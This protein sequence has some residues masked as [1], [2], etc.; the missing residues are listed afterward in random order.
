MLI[1]VSPAKSLD[2]D[3]RLATKKHSQP[4]LLDDAT[5][6]AEVMATKSPDD[7]RRLMTI[8]P[9]LA[10]LNFTRF[11]EWA[12]PFDRRNA[13]PAILTFNGDTYIGLDAPATFSERDYTHAQKVLR[14][15]SGLYGVLR[16]LDLIQPYRLEMGSRVETDRGRDLYGFWGD[17]ITRQ[18]GEDLD[19]SPGSRTLVNLASSE[20]FRAVQPAA[21]DARVVTPTFLDH[22]PDGDGPKVIGFF[23]KRARG[24]MA[25]WIIRNRISSPRSF[26]DFDQLGYRHSPE[27][28]RPGKPAFVRAAPVGPAGV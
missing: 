23:A 2:V 8:S 12:P 22:G 18:L 25:S 10:E 3:S 1:V 26:P 14:I 16:P 17:R 20:Y 28:S 7:L 5:E 21:L 6:L 13:R 27:L 24:A 4:R 19:A 9:E 15:L 11:Q